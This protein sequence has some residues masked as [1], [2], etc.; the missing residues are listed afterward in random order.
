ML[1]LSCNY[2]V[3]VNLKPRPLPPP[4]QVKYCGHKPGSSED[5]ILRLVNQLDLTAEGYID[6]AAKINNFMN[7]K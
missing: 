4:H 2:F 6:F 3:L 1:L 7:N 5:E